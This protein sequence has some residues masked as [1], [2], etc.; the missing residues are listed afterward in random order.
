MSIKQKI[1][2][3]VES[4]RVP[5]TVVAL[6]AA[7]TPAVLSIILI[8]LFL[9]FSTFFG[10]VNSGGIPSDNKTNA[11]SGARYVIAIAIFFG[12]WSLVIAAIHVAVLGFPAAVIGQHLGFIR[13]W[14]STIVGFILG[15][16]PLALSELSTGKAVS[17]SLPGIY[18]PASWGNFAQRVL[19]MGFFGAIG[20]FAFWIVWRYLT[21]SDSS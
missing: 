15:S 5:K 1:D 12:F 7:V 8:S 19:F 14:S 11:I 17:S 20:G 2:D 9:G 13:W 10:N 3:K 18:T 16:L 6:T 21:R 4:P